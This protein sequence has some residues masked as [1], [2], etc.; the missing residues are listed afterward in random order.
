M[1]LL[2]VEYENSI[3]LIVKDKVIFFK[4]RS[5]IMENIFDIELYTPV[6]KSICLYV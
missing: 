6:L 3:S 4:L 1:R 5:L 2:L